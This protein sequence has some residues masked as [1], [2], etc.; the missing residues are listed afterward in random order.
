MTSV[1]TDVHI[2]TLVGQEYPLLWHCVIRLLTVRNLAPKTDDPA[3]TLKLLQPLAPRVKLVLVKRRWDSCRSWP[4]AYCLDMFSIVPV[5]WSP[6]GIRTSIFQS[7]RRLV[8]CLNI[9]SYKWM[10][11]KICTVHNKYQTLAGESDRHTLQTSW[12]LIHA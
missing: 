11:L 3:V 2:S 6:H 9:L 5:W 1:V 10:R 8:S 4:S 12:R 7:R